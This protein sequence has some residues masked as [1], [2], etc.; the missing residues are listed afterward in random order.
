MGKKL[1]RTEIKAARELLM[2]AQ[3]YKCALCDVDFREQTIKNRKRV[4]KAR[5]VLDHCHTHGH[6]R[7]VLCT[8][9]N[10]KFGEGK[11]RQAAKACSRNM[12]EVEWLR[13]LVEYWEKHE[14]PQTQYIHPDH[15][16][17][18]EKRLARNKKERQRRATAKAKALLK[19]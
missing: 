3:G 7:G 6:V 15:K 2:K 10:G 8:T 14:T 12:T 19:D 18:D 13:R 5:D 16:T 17:E 4:S 11:V 9:C 1:K